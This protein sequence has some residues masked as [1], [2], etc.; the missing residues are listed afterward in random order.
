MKHLFTYSAPCLIIMGLS[1]LFCLPLI[2]AGAD[3][4]TV[5]SAEELTQLSVNLIPG[6]SV[7]LQNGTYTDQNFTFTGLGTEDNPITLQAETPGKVILKGSSQLSIAG[8]Y[9]VVDG[10]Q[11]NGGALDSGT[12]IDF[13][14]E[15][16]HCTLRNT[17]IFD[18][19]PSDPETRY[20][21]VTLNGY[22]NIVEYC[23]FSG[24]THSGVTLVVRLQKDVTAGHIIRQNHFANRPEG[25][26]NGYETIRI[27]TGGQ[28]D[29]NARCVVSD[30]L[31]EACNG[32]TEIVSNKSC[33]NTY[34]GN[35]FVACAG[36]LTLRQG[37]R[38]VV[39][40]NAFIAQ[41]TE[42]SGGLRITGQD[43]RISGNY[44]SGTMGRGGAAIALL[45][46]TPGAP[47]GGYPQVERCLIEN[48]TM[49]DNLGALF[50]LDASYEAEG[51]N[52]L[53]IDVTIT[54]TL[55]VQREGSEAVV[56]AEK[57]HTGIKWKNN[58]LL[59]DNTHETVP[60]GI[61]VG[62]ELPEKW[63]KRII[64]PIVIRANYGTRWS[65]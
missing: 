62:A 34:S 52:L 44:F 35:I 22:G 36:T 1:V 30:N 59:T 6:D 60:R 61:Q 8:E 15:S 51:D 13:A 5:S 17:A 29:T 55:M 31:F 14:E 41:D 53:P 47:R 24:Q 26:G 7:V 9:L 37:H 56:D 10:L 46:G 43:H 11:F 18:Y 19:N 28:R 4:Y 64:H 58:Y 54:N 39:E 63:E 3:T 20:C 2:Y 48:N 12:V 38:C 25:K 21:W 50:A 40:N 23:S 65:R 32:E 49:V 45:A 57:E 27:G 33:E 42:G 16:Q